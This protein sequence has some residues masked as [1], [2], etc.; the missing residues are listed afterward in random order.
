MYNCDEGSSAAPVSH[1]QT[2]L[3]CTNILGF[4]GQQEINEI[5]PARKFRI[6]LLTQH[7]RAWWLR[8][9]I[10]KLIHLINTRDYFYLKFLI[11]VL[12]KKTSSHLIAF[13]K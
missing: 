3:L 12:N 6:N 5:L 4:D 10:I 7:T 11:K 8:E 9:F 2:D 13:V 1:Q